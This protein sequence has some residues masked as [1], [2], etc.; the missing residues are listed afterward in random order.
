MRKHTPNDNP[1]WE[2]LFKGGTLR[3]VT[4]WGE[5]VLHAQTRPVTEVDE[6]VSYTHL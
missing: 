2:D 5:S 4:R 6:A 1:L 3:R